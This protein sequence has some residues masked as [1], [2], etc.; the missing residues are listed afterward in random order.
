[1]LEPSLYPGDWDRMEGRRR[2]EGK[3]GRDR[4]HSLYD[5]DRRMLDEKG[6][7]Q[8]GDRVSLRPS[9]LNFLN[10]NPQFYRKKGGHS[11]L[12]LRPSTLEFLN[13]DEREYL[14]DLRRRQEEGDG[15]EGSKRDR[16]SFQ[17]SQFGKRESDER[18]SEDVQEENEDKSEKIGTEGEDIKEVKDESHKQDDVEDDKIDPKDQN[19]SK[20]EESIKDEPLYPPRQSKPKIEENETPLSKKTQSKHY[21]SKNQIKNSQQ[22]SQ[23]TKEDSKQP[24]MPESNPLSNFSGKNPYTPNPESK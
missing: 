9:T 8:G 13:E 10:E 4:T 21:N 24:S 1:M 17:N 18:I 20:K 11:R 14:E 15:E 22:N 6:V 16:I 23:Q 2:N 19:E 5:Y 12:S 3:E 7:K